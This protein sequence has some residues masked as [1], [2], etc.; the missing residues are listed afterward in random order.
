MCRGS[1]SDTTNW[2]A[3]DV[4]TPVKETPIRSGDKAKEETKRR[5]SKFEQ[6]NPF[7]SD[8]T[9]H[10][11]LRTCQGVRVHPEDRPRN[12]DNQGEGN[13]DFGQVVRRIS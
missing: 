9:D 13:N 2:Y 3:T 7:G 11:T 5:R 12:T 8:K 1:V 10:A 6:S 4:R